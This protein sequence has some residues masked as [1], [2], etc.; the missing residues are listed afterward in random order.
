MTGTKKLQDLFVDAK[1]PREMR[2]GVPVLAAERGIFWVAGRWVAGW[3]VAG[4]GTRRAW[5]LSFRRRQGWDGDDDP[6][7]A[8]IDTDFERT[9][10]SWR[11]E[12]TQCPRR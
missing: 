8:Q 3:A 12:R 10:D 7:I 9:D 5:R 6:Q 1:V 2:A 11:V 4:P